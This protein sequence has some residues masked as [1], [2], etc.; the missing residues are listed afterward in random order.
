MY[1]A[2]FRGYLRPQSGGLARGASAQLKLS[3]TRR[4]ELGSTVFGFTSPVKSG[5]RSRI[6]AASLIRLPVT[7]MR[8]PETSAAFAGSMTRSV[9]SRLSPAQS[10]V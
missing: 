2:S 5:E 9:V 3:P 4:I 7:T 10:T 8:A 6:W 1:G